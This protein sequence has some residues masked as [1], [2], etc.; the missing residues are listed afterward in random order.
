MSNDEL[1]RAIE[2]NTIVG[3]ITVLVSLAGIVVTIA[4]MM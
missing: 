2:V 3:V 4:A 1:K